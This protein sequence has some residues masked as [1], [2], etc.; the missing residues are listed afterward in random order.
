MSA[1]DITEFMR[2]SYR[3]FAYCVPL[4]PIP[5]EYCV[6]KGGVTL[7]Y[8]LDILSVYFKHKI[9][10]PYSVALYHDGKVQLHVKREE[11]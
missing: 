9:Y 5:P 7:K 10:L 3:P 11:S 8:V 6:T 1:Y 4:T 2:T